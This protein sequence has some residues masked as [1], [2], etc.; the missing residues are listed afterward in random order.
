MILRF[1]QYTILPDR[2]KKEG[3]PSC[4]IEL[5]CMDNTQMKVVRVCRPMWNV[6]YFTIGRKETKK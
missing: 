2:E 3:V 6:E 5:Y 1:S 4:T